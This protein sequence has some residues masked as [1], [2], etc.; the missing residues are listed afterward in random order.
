MCMDIGM[1][2]E[3]AVVMVFMVV[4]SRNGQTGA[5]SAM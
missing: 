2:E 1:M 3:E 5:D 4:C